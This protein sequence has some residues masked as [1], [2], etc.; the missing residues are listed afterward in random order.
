MINPNSSGIEKNIHVRI[1]KVS[2]YIDTVV[3]LIS[4][5]GLIPDFKNKVVST[6]KQRIKAIYSL[7]GTAVM[8]VYNL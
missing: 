8:N 1:S 2:D 3:D 7:Q 5:S 4:E 6:Y